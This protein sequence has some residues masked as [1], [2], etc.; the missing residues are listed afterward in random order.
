MKPASNKGLVESGI[1]LH[2]DAEKPCCRSSSTEHPPLYNSAQQKI[3]LNSHLSILGKYVF[4]QIY[5]IYRLN[6][7][8][9][10]AFVFSLHLESL[11]S[12]S[13]F[14]QP[15]RNLFYLILSITSMSNE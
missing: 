9:Q 3:Y 6:I 8:S 11:A 1:F 15:R 5:V 2:S 10:M 12:A 4:D 14:N 7:N 13:L